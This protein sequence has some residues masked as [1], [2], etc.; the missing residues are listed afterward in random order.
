MV[1][2]VKCLP[3]KCKDLSLTSSIA[4]KKKKMS[5]TFSVNLFDCVWLFLA[6]HCKKCIRALAC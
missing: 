1:Q 5:N 2:M 4:E 6:T 3:S